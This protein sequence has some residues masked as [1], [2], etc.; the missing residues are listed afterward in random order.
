MVMQTPFLCIQNFIL[1]FGGLFNAE[2]LLIGH[3]V[4]QNNASVVFFQSEATE[5]TSHDLLNKDVEETIVMKILKQ[6]RTNVNY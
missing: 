3:A 1:S 4:T 6:F 2:V 5:N